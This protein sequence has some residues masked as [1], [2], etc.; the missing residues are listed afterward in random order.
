MEK[1]FKLGKKS[2]ESGYYFFF[3]F[4]EWRLFCEGRIIL[5][6]KMNFKLILKKILII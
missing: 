3:L 2:E 4:G 5:G 1:I 6:R